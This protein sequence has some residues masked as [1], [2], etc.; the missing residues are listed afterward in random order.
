[1]MITI[2][3]N[4]MVTAATTLHNCAVEAADIG[5]PLTSSAAQAMPAD[6]QYVV[7]QMVTTVDRALDAVAMR[8]DVQAADLN[9]RAQIAVNDSVAAAAAAGTPATFAVANA[10]GW[11]VDAGAWMDPM[12]A[13]V[14]AGFAVGTGSWMGGG[15]GGG[16]GGGLGGGTGRVAACAWGGVGGGGA[17]RVMAPAVAWA[18]G[19]VR[20][21]AACRVMAPAVAW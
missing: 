6:V 11:S 15:S 4:E 12:S 13:N 18:W 19:R 7:D 17:C 2:D 14:S 16:A 3:P 10:N 1:M 5:S 8:L 21:W 20:G 9:A